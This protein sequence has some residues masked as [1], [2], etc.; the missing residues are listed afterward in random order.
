MPDF[1]DGPVSWAAGRGD[2]TTMKVLLALRAGVT[3]R[4]KEAGRLHH[5]ARAED[6]SC[7]EALLLAGAKY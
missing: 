5:T 1:E 4:D 6:L 3:I 7:I 2:N